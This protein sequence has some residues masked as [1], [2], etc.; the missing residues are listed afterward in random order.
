M[1]EQQYLLSVSILGLNLGWI[2]WVL[3]LWSSV[4]LTFKE[5]MLGSLLLLLLL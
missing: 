4:V 2:S 5:G 3:R 1:I